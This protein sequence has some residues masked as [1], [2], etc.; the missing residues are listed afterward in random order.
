MLS[1]L[2]TVVEADR[3]GTG[4]AIND[5]PS[6]ELPDLAPA[7][8]HHFPKMNMFKLGI[9]LGHGGEGKIRSANFPPENHT[10][11]RCIL[12]RI[13]QSVDKIICARIPE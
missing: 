2:M 13:G 3:D 5:E 11:V 12:D 6:A 9:R 7:E 4:L 10:A 1:T 8:G